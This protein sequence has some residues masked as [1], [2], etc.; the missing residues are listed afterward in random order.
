MA[1]PN[2]VTGS[3]RE[4][5]ASPRRGA[6]SF[7]ITLEDSV[8]GAPHPQRHG[9]SPKKMINNPIVYDKGNAFSQIYFDFEK[10]NFVRDYQL[11]FGVSG[12]N[13]FFGVPDTWE[14]YSKITAFINR[15]YAR[16]SRRQRK[17]FWQFWK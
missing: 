3:A 15:A 7:N 14:N 11:A 10:G 2:D 1:G 12:G 8:A 13:D 5:S 16:G 4:T 6:A 17:C 9:R